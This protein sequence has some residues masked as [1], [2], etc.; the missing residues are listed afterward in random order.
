MQ[1]EIVSLQT[2]A[3]SISDALSVARATVACQTSRVDEL[4]VKV[5]SVRESA[6]TMVANAQAMY[7]AD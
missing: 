4:E 6:G 2:E 3:A 5:K 7:G 1:V